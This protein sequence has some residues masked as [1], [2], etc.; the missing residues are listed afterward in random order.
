MSPEKLFWPIT[1]KRPAPGLGLAATSLHPARGPVATAARRAD[2]PQPR[3]PPLAPSAVSRRPR[4]WGISCPATAGSLLRSSG[5]DLRRLDGH[6][7]RVFR[8]PIL[9]HQ[10]ERNRL[11]AG[12]TSAGGQ[13]HIARDLRITPSAP[14]PAI[15]ATATPLVVWPTRSKPTPTN[16][17]LAAAGPT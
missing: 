6:R 8:V 9:Q 5:R 4:S 1:L 10:V 12:E 16:P 3:R 14:G 15:A 11:D 2:G 13:N 17:P 7:M